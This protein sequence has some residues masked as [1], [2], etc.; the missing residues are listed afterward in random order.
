MCCSSGWPIP[1]ERDR[2][3]R[4]DQI[5]SRDRVPL[6]VQPWLVADPSAPEEFAGTL[7]LRD[8][9]HC[10]FFEAKG[11]G[12]AVYE[13]RPASCVHFPYVCL[14]DP[15]GVRVTLSHYCPTAAEM[16]FAPEG[17]IGIVPGPQPVPDTLALEGLD[18]R[19]SLPPVL[20]DGRLMTWEG[21]DRWERDAVAQARIGEMRDADLALFEH[22]RASVPLPWSWPAAPRDAS[23]LWWSHAAPRWHHFEHVLTRYSAAKIFGSW[24][25]Y[26]GN[27]V[28]AILRGL[29]VAAAV[30][31][32]ECARQCAM[33]QQPLDCEML[34]EAIRQTDLL[35]VH[36]ADPAFLCRATGASTDHPQG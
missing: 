19:E 8:N 26:K 36:Y 11:A 9:G 10:V 15:R 7:A 1:V 32:V 5:V 3:I 33:Y 20:D 30:L 12:C 14:I 2:V 13:A 27:G 4:I 25:A 29:E 34:K 28:E 17:P 35:L 24:A 21:F 22:A 23:D 16:L 31:R 6:R 18:A